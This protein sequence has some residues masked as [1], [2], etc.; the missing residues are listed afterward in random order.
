M[1]AEGGAIPV[2]VLLPFTAQYSWVG[3]N[4]MEVAQLIVNEANETGGIGG[5]EVR[6]VQGDTEGTVD[7][8]VLAAQKLASTDQ[9]VAFIGPTSLSFTG[10]RQVVTDTGTPMVSPTA[11]T[12]ELNEAGKELFYRTVP[13]DSLGGRAIAR[14]ITDPSLLGRDQAFTKPALLVGQAPALISF[15]EPIRSGI[16]EFGG[17]L[18]TTLEFQ[19]GKSAYRSEVGE[20]LNAEPDIIILVA[21]PEDS[22]R[23]Q[24]DAFEAGYQGG[25]F[26]TQDQTNA[27]YVS[28]AGPEV[29][30]GIY[31][32]VE[33]APPEA[34]DL[35]AT[36]REQLGHEPDIF[37][38]NSY[39]AVNVVL[40]AL[41]EAAQA[42]EEISRQALA[43][44]LD[45]V[46]NADEGDVVVTSFTEGREALEAGDSIDYQGLSGPVDFDEFGNIV[47]PFAIQQVQDGTWTEVAILA[48]EDLR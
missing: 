15:A 45:P 23:I 44:S 43:G 38:T 30:E 24:R 11:G 19:P 35:L 7:A 47:S 42:G 25:W 29:V 16:E 2:G 37:Q 48:A 31:G 8:G 21:A 22:A 1:A 36:F 39:D 14:A 5:R 20:V 46:A 41:L 13:S 17:S 33:A 12:T 34:E 40:L 27:D 3:E 28:L 18:A 26:V 9:V 6:L 32:L 4:V 10:V